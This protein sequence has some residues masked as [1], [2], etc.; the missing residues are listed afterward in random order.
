[1]TTQRGDEYFVFLD[2]KGKRWPRLRL[3]IVFLATLLF[4]ALVLFFQSLLVTSQLQ[5]PA[6]IR[7]MK[8]RL[9]VLETRDAQILPGK[10]KALWNDFAKAPALD[11]TQPASRHRDRP[12]GLVR[13][14]FSVDWDPGSYESLREHGSEL[15]HLCPEWLTMTDGEGNMAV[16]RDTLAADLANKHH[17][18]LL[19]LLSNLDGD[20]ANPEAVEGIIN[21]PVERRAHFVTALLAELRTAGAGGVVVDWMEI[22]VA[23]RQAMTTFLLDLATALHDGKMELWLCVPAGVELNVYD[24][25]K[26]AAGVDRFIA[27]LHDENSEKDPPGPIASQEWFNGW[28]ETMTE[29]G[30]PEQWVVA[31]GSYGYDWAADELPAEEIDFD[32]VMTRAGRAGLRPEDIDSHSLNPHF[33]Y[34]DNGIPHT[35]WFLDAITAFNQVR[36]V[37]ASQAGGV[38]ISRLGTEDPGIWKVLAMRDVNTP[39]NRDLAAL[40]QMRAEGKTSHVGAGEFLTVEPTWENGVRQVRLDDNGTVIEHLEKFPTYRTVFHQGQ[41]GVDQVAIT[42]DDG[43]DPVYT[44]RILDILKQEEVKAAFFLVGSNIESHPAVV[45]RIVDEGHEIG[46]HTYTH[47]NLAKV[48]NERAFLEL[49]ATERLIETVTNRSTTLFRP[50]YNADSRPHLEEELRAVQLAQSLGYLTVSNSVDPEDWHDATREGIIERIKELR[51]HGN[52]ILL[53]DAGGNRSATVAALPEVIAYLKRRGDSIVPLGAMLGVSPEFLMPPLRAEH[54][55]LAQVVSASGFKTLHVIEELLWAFMIVATVLTFVRAL[56]VAALAFVHRRRERRNTHLTPF[57]PPVSVVLA[58]YNEAKVIRETLSAL[59]D[60]RY[61]GPLQIVV[62][63]DGS[64]DATA[65]IVGEIAAADQRVRLVATP[66][67]GKA[68]ALQ[69][70]FVA[71]DH[72]V[73]VT[74][75]ADTRFTPDTIAHLVAPLRDDAAAA[76]SGHVMVGNARTFMARCQSLEYICGFNLDRRAYD[77]LDCITVVPGAA[78]CLRKSAVIKAGGISTDTLAEDTD[79]TLALHRLGRRVRYAPLAIAWTEVPESFAE[80]ARQRFRW[81]FGTLQCLWKHRDLV[82]K[83]GQGPLGWFSLPGTWFFQIFLVA[84]TPLVDLLLLL[85]LFWGAGAEISLYFAVFLLTDLFLA[86]AACLVEGEPLRQAWL[87]VPMRFLYRPLLAWVVWKSIQKALKG[88]WVRWD[89][90]KRTAS[91]VTH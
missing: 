8:A 63:D 55:S 21:G 66:N 29:Y 81:G 2:T 24:L 80:L 49:N 64:S 79:L 67:R 58:A 7:E 12:P 90:L 88:A 83:P 28:L 74:L 9:K 60:T 65:A 52:V 32:D 40:G 84:L 57:Q 71:A 61:A 27:I 20:D 50:P 46:I 31:I 77:L 30:Q 16:K 68:R 87:M 3:L 53:H 14:G 13:L 1:M 76:V 48:S 70:G 15:T 35:V 91:V 73:L 26:L 37:T 38:A 85:S 42:F 82:F 41:G 86:V 36:A 10:H 17:L 72:E 44:P 11:Q 34:L 54:P 59:L 33:Q 89:K 4:V 6:A 25:E 5:L 19:P 23:Y 51:P 43:P 78:S 18:V 22:D 47:P 69:T 75:D 56:F 39:T 62:V 45:R